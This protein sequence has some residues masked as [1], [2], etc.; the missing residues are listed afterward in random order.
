MSS[1]NLNNKLKLSSEFTLQVNEM[2]QKLL[3][4]KVSVVAIVTDLS[5]IHI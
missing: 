5:L 1:F 2:K 3:A 4:D